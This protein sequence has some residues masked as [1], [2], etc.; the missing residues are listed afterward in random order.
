[1]NRPRR[2]PTDFEN[3]VYEAIRTIPEGRVATY[4]GLARHL[5]CGSAQAVGQALRRNPFA[6]TTPCHRVVAADGRLGGFQG[7]RDGGPLAEKRRLLETEGVRF[8]PDG[9][10][11]SS[12][13]YEFEH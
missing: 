5:G 11:A 8:G 2:P 3:R 7:E 9:A 13:R 4:G 10:V 1:M 12:C 6:P